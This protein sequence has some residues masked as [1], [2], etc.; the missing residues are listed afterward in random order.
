MSIQ[1]WRERH[2]V[3]WL[4]APPKIGTMDFHHIL[5][6]KDKLHHILSK[7]DELHHIR[8]SLAC[9]AKELIYPSPWQSI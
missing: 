4:V 8:N 6:K 5:S 2:R 9:G 3:Y 7:K 1:G